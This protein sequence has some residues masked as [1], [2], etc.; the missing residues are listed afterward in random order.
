MKPAATVHSPFSKTARQAGGM[1]LVVSMA[2][3]PSFIRWGSW[4]GEVSE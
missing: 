4:Q 2:V 1:V 3:K